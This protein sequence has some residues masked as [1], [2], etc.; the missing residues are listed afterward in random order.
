MTAVLPTPTPMAAW[1]GTSYSCRGISR[2]SLAVM[3]RP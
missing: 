3:A 1:I 2:L